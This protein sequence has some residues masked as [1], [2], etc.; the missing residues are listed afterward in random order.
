M[1]RLVVETDGA[2]L[3][4]RGDLDATGAV[5]LRR[6]VARAARAGDVVVELGGVERMTTVGAAGLLSGMRLA[7]QRGAQVRIE[8]AKESHEQVLSLMPETAR[9]PARL[10][11]ASPPFF[12]RLGG[13]GY[14]VGA[15]LMKFAELIMDTA[16]AVGRMVKRRRVAARGAFTEQAVSVGVNALGIVGLL[17]LLLGVIMAF[18]AS[19][20]LRRFGADVYV[21]DLVGIS[22]VRELGPMM[23]AIILSGRSGAAMAAE[24]ATMTVQEEVDALRTMGLD[25]VGFLVVPRL[26]AILAMQPAL[27]LMSMVVGVTGGWFAAAAFL[28]LPAAVYFERLVRVLHM[29]DIVMGLVKSVVFAA[30]IGFVSCSL[31]LGVRGGPSGVGRATTRAVV[32]SIFL[33]IVADSL[34]AIVTTLGKS[35]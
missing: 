33:I 22:M 34:F 31:G 27:T 24:L 25:P 19:F 21:V 35:A 26:T 13:G 11:P 20:Q 5:L 4:P 9:E 28:D 12:E 14:E 18:Q 1:S 32:T 3:R 10:T 30:I 23:T 16:I 6:A 2:T 17:S 7:R 15:G 8:G 29:D